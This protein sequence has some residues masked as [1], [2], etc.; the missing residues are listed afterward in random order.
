MEN[1]GTERAALPP[2]K[3]CDGEWISITCWNDACDEIVVRVP[4]F[5]TEALARDFSADCRLTYA[6]QQLIL[7]AN[8][9]APLRIDDADVEFWSLRVDPVTLFAARDS[10]LRTSIAE[11]FSATTRVT[12]Q[13][14]RTVRRAT[15][16]ALRP[17]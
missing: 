17:R 12:L 4:G 14:S 3:P 8:G 13:A 6:Q 15:S 1:Y 5:A 16:E 10:R 2:P 11:F 7:V 9:W